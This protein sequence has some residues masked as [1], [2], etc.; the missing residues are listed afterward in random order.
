M[1][2]SKNININYTS[3]EF[4]TIKE[5]LVDYA[6]RYYPD[7]YKDFTDAS[8][9]SLVLDTVTYVGDVLSYYVDYSVNESFLDTAVE[10]ENVRKHA[11]SLGYN[12]SGIPSSYGF[13]TVYILCPSNAEGTAPDLLYLPTIKVGSNFSTATGVNFT[14]TEDILFNSVNNEFVAARFDGTTGATTHLADR[15]WETNTCCGW[16]IRPYFYCW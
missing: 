9:G 13:I 11:R 12:Y 7:S 8:F 6:K 4:N 1:P 10:Y 14:L 2:K 5:D 16:K 3:R 15:D